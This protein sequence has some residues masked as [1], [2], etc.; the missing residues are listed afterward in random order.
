MVKISGFKKAS[1]AIGE[2]V[3]NFFNRGVKEAPGGTTGTKSP[4]GGGG[5]GGQA[6]TLNNL[7]QFFIKAVTGGGQSTGDFESPDYDLSDIKAATAADSY[8]KMAIQKHSQLIFKAGYTINSNNDAAAE[9]IRSRLRMMSFATK[10]P[11]DILWQ[12]IGEDLTRYSNAFLVKSRIDKVM[13]GAQ[14]KGVFNNKAVGGYFRIDP[15]TVQIKRDASGVIQNYQQQIGSTTKTFNALDVIHFYMEKDAQ[16]AFGTPRCV[17]VL[18]DIKILRQIEGNVLSLIYRFALPIYQWIVG[19][20]DPGYMATEKEMTEARD[21]VNKMPMDGVIITNERTQIKAVGAEGNALDCSGY[22]NYYEKRVFSGLNVSEAMMGRGGAK[23]DADSMEGQLHDTVKYVQRTISVFIRDQVF[24]ELLLEG[25]YDPINN[26]DDIVTFDFNEIN[27]DTKVKMENHEMLKWQSNCVPFEEVR[28]NLGLR[29]DNVDENR[30]YFNMVEK[31]TSLAEIGAKNEAA[32]AIAGARAANSGS[33]SSSGSTQNRTG[34]NGATKSAAPNKAVST[35]NRPT[36]QHGTTSAKVKESYSVNYGS[37]SILL[38]EDAKT[39]KNVDKYRKFFQGVYKKY[40]AARN[41]ILKH[42]KSADL[43]LPLAKDG[44]VSELN[45][46]IDMQ[47]QDGVAKAY[48]DHKKSQATS[49]EKIHANLLKRSVE[50][51][52]TNLMKDI[53]KAVEGKDKDIDVVFDTYEYRL[54]FA[55]THITAKAY[56]YGYVKAC[57]SMDVKKVK[58]NFNG[59]ADAEDH[60]EIID[61]KNFKLDDIPA[62]HAYCDCEI[63]PDKGR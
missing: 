45:R 39:D 1:E 28:Q 2:K 19:L 61:T 5:G 4:G 54:R 29:S 62:Y 13:G 34:G 9:Y 8:L 10:K 14:A 26:P 22:L 55:C 38:A 6:I 27:L 30:L 60:E 23:Q 43:V 40:E 25:G 32:L 33:G 51:T 35:N 57:A 63:V 48:R 21:A 16:S 18:E 52:V 31:E 12:E 17:A 11:V 58:V 36:N 59:S 56:W 24:V 44:I 41:D 49:I 20:T 50:Y 47:I 42:P 53:K 3:I 7:K 46:V 37:K 15:D